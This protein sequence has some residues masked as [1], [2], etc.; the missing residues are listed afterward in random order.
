MNCVQYGQQRAHCLS[1]TV[2]NLEMPDRSVEQGVMETENMHVV[3]KH[4][5]NTAGQGIKSCNTVA[6][7]PPECCGY[8]AGAIDFFDRTYKELKRVEGRCGYLREI[9]LCSDQRG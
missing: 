4:A 9:V 7:C 3:L 2:G 6:I 8:M 5:F 1:L